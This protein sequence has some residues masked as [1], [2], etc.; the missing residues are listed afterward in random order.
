MAQLAGP[1]TAA[2]ESNSAATSAIPGEGSRSG[3]GAGP[4]LIKENAMIDRTDAHRDAGFK[5]VTRR[6]LERVPLVG[7]RRELMVVEV[8]YPPGGV[9]PIHRHPV[10]GAIYIVEGVAESAYGNDEPRRYRAGETLQ[11]RADFP[12][13]HFRNCDPDKPLRFLTMYVL[14]PDASYTSEA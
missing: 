7:D 2:L 12:H 14:E 6:T 5:G 11:D 13:T 9:A 3:A 1:H 10:G 4:F 8:T